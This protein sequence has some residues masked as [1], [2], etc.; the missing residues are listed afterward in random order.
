MHIRRLRL[1][2][3]R[4]LSELVWHPSPGLN[5]L[6]GPGDAGKTTVLEAVA[7]ILSP[8]P[9]Q[10]A[11]ELDYRNLDTGTSF[12]VE[13]VIG[14]LSDELLA[15]CFPAPLSG[16]RAKDQTL[17][18]GPSDGDDGVESVLVLQLTG[19]PDLEL[20]HEL[21]QP[22]AASRPLTVAQRNAIG[23]WNVTGGRGA[24]SQLRMSG[25]SLLE[26]ALGRD[27][28]RAPAAAALRD[29]RHGLQ[30]P[31][32]GK[33]RLTLV[34][35]RLKAAG[36][37]LGRLD[38]AITP[39]G[40]QTPVQ[41]LNLIVVTETGYVP[42]S[43]FGHGTQQMAMVALATSQASTSPIAV[44][45]EIE[46]GLE[47]YRHR[48][49]VRSLR[50]TLTAHGQAFLTTHSGTVLSL[51]SEGEAWRM[52][53]SARSVEVRPLLGSLHK[54]LTKDP[55]AL[56]SHLPVVC[57]GATEVGFADVLLRNATALGMPP[58]DSVGIR[59]V[60]GQGHELALDLTQ[61]FSDL[62]IPVAVLVD[63]ESF[64]SGTRAAL[65]SRPGV[66][67]R[68]LPGGSCTEAVVA[69]ALPT[70]ALDLL[71]A[72]PGRDGPADQD[73]R[74]KAVTT[75]LGDQRVCDVAS[76][77]SAHGER[78]TREA[79]GVAA[80]RGKWFKSRAAGAELAELVFAQ[81]PETEPLRV[82]MADF[83]TSV[84]GQ[85]APRR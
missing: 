80:H 21:V 49:L 30:V 43:S 17:L 31:D 28:M 26:R 48:E 37:T 9:S 79:I 14:D 59:L 2:E 15:A 7:L 25:G 13:V 66:T 73:A 22:G 33:R 53:A 20:R 62:G 19:T 51:L 78:E 64:R 69:A 74:M 82:A 75:Q 40:G 72:L 6:I 16:W 24:Q 1:K 34:E 50:E 76:A 57:E 35:D 39:G 36:L 8:N 61:A 71:I 11:S 45:D 5:V 27:V 84:F 32:E 42:L 81:V 67:L 4:S 60:D 56:L 58:Y 46:V 55:E 18:P 52:H 65:A 70:G 54:T 47:P 10:A 68:T 83:A 85:I 44:L 38:L 29:A 23:L 41:L 77:I 63:E 12:T 3:F